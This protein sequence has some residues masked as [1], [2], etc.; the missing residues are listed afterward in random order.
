MFYKK[1]SA[2]SAMNVQDLNAY[3]LAMAKV[4]DE[5]VAKSFIT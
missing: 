1:L 3:M 4:V 5:Q 2:S